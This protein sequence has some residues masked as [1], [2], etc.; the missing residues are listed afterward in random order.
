MYASTWKI[1]RSGEVFQNGAGS[2][3]VH[4]APEA[5]DSIGRLAAGLLLYELRA[6]PTENPDGWFDPSGAVGLCT[7][8][9][10]RIGDLVTLSGL[11]RNQ[12]HTISPCVE[13]DPFRRSRLSC[14]MGAWEFGIGC[15]RAGLQ[16]LMHAFFQRGAKRD[17]QHVHGHTSV[18]MVPDYSRSPTNLGSTIRIVMEK[19]L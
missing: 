2:C 11:E 14:P 9:F 4:V 3:V 12:N 19:R 10:D 16:Y 8:G 17:H 1:A 18:Q 6:G 5:P 7:P 13:R 15:D